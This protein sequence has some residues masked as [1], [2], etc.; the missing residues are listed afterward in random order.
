MDQNQC[1]ELRDKIFASTFRT[2]RPGFPDRLFRFLAVE[3]GGVGGSD[4]TVHFAY[5]PAVWERAGYGSTPNDVAT[6]LEVTIDETPYKDKNLALQFHDYLRGG[7]PIAWGITAKESFNN[8]PS[9]VLLED[10]DGTV[11]GVLMRDSHSGD[12]NAR[13]ANAYAEPH[14][15]E[16][17]INELTALAPDE[18]FMGW[19]KDCNITAGSIDAAIAL[20]PES[21]AGQKHVLVYRE[22]EWL[23]G[24]WNNPT[25]PHAYPMKLSSVADFHGTRVSAAK[26]RSRGG[27]D[28]AKEK[29][30]IPGD[31]A[32]LDE[33]LALLSED[34]DSAGADYEAIPAIKVL[35]AWWNT[36][37]P[38]SMRPAALFRVY[39]WKPHRR[40]F[41]A[42]D[43]EE[44]A[45][46]ACD[47]ASIPTYAIFEREG[48][49]TV[50]LTFF[51]GRIFNKEDECGTQTFYANGEDGWQ[52]G[53]DLDQVDEAYYALKGLQAIEPI[54]KGHQ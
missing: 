47:L 13:L 15:V 12:V 53:V 18:Q 9:L 23:W 22:M 34:S 48:H 17:L 4:A 8:F 14:E 28:V 42:G 2:N 10:D 54:L 19:Y 39:V 51:R 26:R 50:A 41:V 45:V 52:I 25:K 11:R 33:A 36:H 3:P 1:A 32:V 49:P 20:T 44:P 38:E 46:Q 5:A 35:C 30:T 24:L 37:A 29:Q 31:Y 27:L 6:L 43:P 7:W 40:T 21:D 16:D